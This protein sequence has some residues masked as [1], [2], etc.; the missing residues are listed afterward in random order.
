M[1]NKILEIVTQ[2]PK[3]YSRLIRK[4]L[5][6]NNWVVQNSLIQ[7]DNFAE[8]ITSAINE[9]KPICKNGKKQPFLSITKGWTFCGHQRECLCS[10]ESTAEKVSDTKLAWN[11]EKHAEANRRRKNTMVERYGFEF[12]SQREDIKHIWTKPKIDESVWNLLNDHNWL[13]NEYMVKQRNLSD[14]ADQ[15]DVYYGTVGEYCHKQ[16][17]EIRQFSK[18]SKEE[19]QLSNWLTEIG[20]NHTRNDRQIFDGKELDIL[21]PDKNLAI[22]IN[23]LQWHSFHPKYNKPEDRNRHLQKT[24]MATENGI[25]LLHFTDWQWNNKRDIVKSIIKSKL[26]IND[27]LYARQCVIKPVDKTTAKIFLENYHIQGYIFA[28]FTYGLF[29]NNELKTLVSIGRSRFNKKHNWEVLRTCS[30]PGITVVGGLSKLMKHI[31]NNHIGSIISYCDRSRSN[32][33]GYISAGF[34]LVGS[35]DPGYFWTNGNITISRYRTQKHR[36]SKLLKNFD[37][38]QSG[39]ENMFNTGWQRF[40]DCG[41][42]IFEWK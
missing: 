34:T 26:G 5:E 42:L 25:D 41:N 19:T 8:M 40:W 11:K 36:L 17:F 38:N 6:L 20:M 23:G 13:H 10:K 24:V 16:G 9:F 1:K 7:S 31:S 21:I 22:E 2:S 33:R 39:S 30:L 37:P 18:F 3:H 28:D 32:G 4:D 29:Q 35:S 15:L 14:I 12:N 27:R